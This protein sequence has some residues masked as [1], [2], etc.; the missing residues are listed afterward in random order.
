MSSNLILVQTL[1]DWGLD[2]GLIGE[3]QG[4][5]VFTATARNLSAYYPPPGAPPSYPFNPTILPCAQ[6]LNGRKLVPN[7]P[8]M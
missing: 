3:L 7:T 5:A 1:E 2:K 6:Q 4:T 8:S